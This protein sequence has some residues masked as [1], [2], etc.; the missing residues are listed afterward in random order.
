MKSID[1]TLNNEAG[2]H[3][4]PASMFI[5]EVLKYS[6]DVKVIKDEQEYNGRSIMG[7]LSMGAIKGSKLTIICEGIDESEAIIGLKKLI[8]SNFGE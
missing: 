3:A 5:R 8:D 7:I 6:S 4:R 2:L 1:V